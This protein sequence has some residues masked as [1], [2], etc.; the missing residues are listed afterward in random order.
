MAL[1]VGCCG[2]CIGRSRY[3]KLFSVV[4][5]Q[6]TFYNPPEPGRLRALRSEAPP[7]FAFTMK[8][9]QAVTH[10]LDSPTW[11][12]ARVLPDASLGDRYG[13]LRPTKEVFEAWEAV[14]RGARALDARV[15]IIQTP[16]SFGYTEQNLRNAVE[17][18]SSATAS[19]ITIGW[20]P[21]GTW[22][23]NPDKILE[24][25]SMFRGVV[26]VVDPFK[27]R[28]VAVKEVTYFRLHGMGGSAGYSYRYTD[29]DLRK[30]RS[31]ADEYLRQ[32]RDVYVM[33][34]NVYMGQDAR[35]FNELTR[36]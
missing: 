24:V 7:G 18:L 20:E 13:L 34:N 27:S 26:H 23:Q 25:V 5:L 4:E 1:Y 2:F 10:P 6:D 32:S 29:G 15:V 21:R 19:G 11:R 17:F 28:P 8:C 9:W 22:L 36:A 14:V 33:F 30:L 16:P 35:R 31:I 12:R 3:F